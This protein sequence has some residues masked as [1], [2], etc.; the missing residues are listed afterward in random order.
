[1]KTNSFLKTTALL[2]GSFL[3]LP[4]QAE[5]QL[6]EQIEKG[7]SVSAE[8]TAT[9]SWPS[10]LADNAIGTLVFI[11]GG[12]GSAGMKAT[13]PDQAPY[14]SLYHFNQTLKRLS[15]PQATSGA[16]NVVIYDNPK[17]FTD[18]R[19][20]SERASNDHMVR[21]E[22]VIKYYADKFKKP[23]W[24][25]GHSNGGFSIAEFQK[26][27]QKNNKMNLVQGLIFSAGRDISS[28]GSDINKPVLVVISENDGCQATTVAN[29]QR[30]FE[31]IRNGNQWPTE[32]AW[33]K[34]SLPEA[35]DPCFSGTHMYFGAGEEVANVLNT[36]LL[37]HSPA[38]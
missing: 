23:V 15:D 28:F 27:L 30:V 22:S 13:W 9:F 37:R 4:S 20:L 38:K 29:A 14:L 32:F 12:D 2:M 5:V 34:G 31:K 11:P 1:M 26:Y 7:W 36:F 6:V 3:C 10:G 18:L 35:K 8:P 25:M 33:I 17:K 19:Y 24:L 21:I 16:F